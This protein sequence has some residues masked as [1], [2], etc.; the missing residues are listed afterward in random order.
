MSMF[1]PI[2][3]GGRLHRR[4][5]RRRRPAVTA[6]LVVGLA[7]AVAAAASWWFLL[8]EPDTPT[9][10]AA[11][12]AATCPKPKPTAATL[13]KPADV[14]VNVYNSTDRF[15]LAASVSEKL[16]AREYAVRTVDNDPLQRSIQGV[17]EVRHGPAGIE[18]ARTIVAVVPGA[19]LVPTKRASAQ[20]DL[21]L[22]EGFKAL[23]DKPVPPMVTP[24]PKPGC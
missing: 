23:A 2:G 14:S 12:A 6:V 20:V 7:V 5:R 21:A 8:R 9:V 1:T 11:A 13:L 3:T 4:P 16:A 18:E 10:A 22:G 17:A 19:R 15:G 24:Q